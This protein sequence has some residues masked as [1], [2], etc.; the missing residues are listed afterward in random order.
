M[1]TLPQANPRKWEGNCSPFTT[2]ISE[3]AHA[4]T[5]S[6]LAFQ[7]PLPDNSDAILK[8]TV[9]S[10]CQVDSSYSL[11]TLS[12]DTRLTLLTKQRIRA[13]V[14]WIEGYRRMKFMC[15]ERLD[16]WIFI[17]LS[18]NILIIPLK[19]IFKIKLDE[20]GDVL[21]NKAR[22]VAKGYRQEA[23]IDFCESFA[24]GC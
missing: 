4:V 22:L 6:L 9:R 11:T 15:I 10:C 14:G 7:I 17:T 24:S 19:W 1:L 3:G 16:V 8:N 20:Y 21:K 5:E 2:V 23:G 18:D 12:G 13:F